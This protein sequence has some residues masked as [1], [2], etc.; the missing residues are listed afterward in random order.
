MFDPRLNL[1]KQV[2]EQARKYFGKKVF[3]TIIHRNIRLA[4]AP[5]YGK[6]ILLYDISS[7]GA[8]NYLALAQEIIN[9]S[10][11]DWFGERA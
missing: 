8:Q 5:S 2:V 6:P 9:G 3:K 7:R 1:A 4:E 11:K 10:K